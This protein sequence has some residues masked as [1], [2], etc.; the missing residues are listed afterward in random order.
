MSWGA[1]AGATSYDIHVDG[2]YLTNTTSTSYTYNV[3]STSNRSITIY[4]RNASGREN[5][6]RSGTAAMS[7]KYS[8]Y[9]TGSGTFQAALPTLPAPVVT[10]LDG[11]PFIGY[12]Y[13]GGGFYL[14]LY[15]TNYLAY[16]AVGGY[17]SI[18]W[19]ST[20]GFLYLGFEGDYPDMGV[21]TYSSTGFSVQLTASKAGYQS[22]STTISG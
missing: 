18:T 20:N 15:L 4:S 13:G 11:G 9:Q 22:S 7:T 6:G 17:S 5:T 19:G 21:R 16:D 3:G 12:S 14:G 1:G 8:G 2:A 10:S